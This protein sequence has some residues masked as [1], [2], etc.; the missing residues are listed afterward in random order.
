MVNGKAYCGVPALARAF[1]LPESII[2]SRL[3]RGMMPEQ[4]V[5]DPYTPKPIRGVS[6]FEIEQPSVNHAARAFNQPIGRVRSRVRKLGWSLE[7]ALT[8][9]RVE[10]SN[11]KPFRVSGTEYPSMRAASLAFEVPLATLWR[12]VQNGR[13]PDEALSRA[14]AF[15]QRGPHIV[16]GVEYPSVSAATAAY[17]V[18]RERVASR[19]RRGISLE[20]TILEPREWKPH[21]KQP[22]DVVTVDGITATVAE[23]A[24]R[25][26]IG[27]GTVMQRWRSRV[28]T[29]ERALTT[30]LDGKYSIYTITHCDTG[31]AYVG[32][33]THPENRWDQHADDRISRIGRA[34][35]EHG[36]DAFDRAVVETVRTVEAA[37]AAEERWIADLKAVYNGFNTNARSSYQPRN[38]PVVVDGVKYR[39]EKAARDHYG[40]S[41]KFIN[42]R[43]ARGMEF[44]EAVK[45]SRRSTSSKPVNVGDLGF[46]SRQAACADYGV[47]RHLVRSFARANGVTWGEA[48]LAVAARDGDKRL[49]GSK[50]VQI[51]GRAFATLKDAY[52]FYRVTEIMVLTRRRRGMTIEDAILDAAASPHGNRGRGA[53][54]RGR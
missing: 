34:I 20:D 9:N 22:T 3:A 38:D 52:A 4:A 10:H 13:S 14:L 7:D 51:E 30:S 43:R 11:G 48:V 31:R 17:G 35:A 53:D 45:D 5:S 8:G 42:V 1:G 21:P 15:R 2:Y 40:V 47:E 37:R 33:S 19:M 6:A 36:R 18:P 16:R 49:K 23:H 44:A 28:W 39:S 12:N 54:E 32:V 26:G 41:A 46:P 29:V 50:A 24:A 25:I 27:I